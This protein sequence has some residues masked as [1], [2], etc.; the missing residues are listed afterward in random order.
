MTKVGDTVEIVSHSPFWDGDRGKV[1]ESLHNGYYRIEFPHLD[2]LCAT[3]FKEQL[4]IINPKKKKKLKQ[5]DLI[6]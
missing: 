4:G 5:K 3:F 6:L 2:N 1:I